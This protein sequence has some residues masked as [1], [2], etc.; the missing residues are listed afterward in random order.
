MKFA[1]C[2]ET[3]EGW[4]FPDVCAHL[5]A[6][7]YQG[8]EIAPFTLKEDPRELTVAEAREHRAVAEDAGLEIVGLHWL[9]VKPSW[10][11]MT[12]P[13]DLLR[14][15]TVKF[16]AHLAKICGAMGGNVMV[17]GSPRQRNLEKD[18]EYEAAA[19]RAA[20]VLRAA[21]EAA[22]DHGV[23]IALEPLGRAET[24]FLTTAAEGV[25]LLKRV[26]HPACRLHLD[27]KA[28]SDEPD[29]IPDIIRAQADYLAHFHAND[30]NLRGPGFGEVKFEP[31]AAALREVKYDGWVSVEVFD[32]RPDPETIAVESL[33]YLRETFGVDRPT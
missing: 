32:Y 7:G 9:L 12:T 24:N 10:L 6:T 14:K 1:F 4:S 16:A 21:A 8:I 17:W 25:E 22:A 11:H 15:D 19:E 28:M 23:V 27:V 30:P 29:E 26:D 20:G 18:W 33:A 5:A 2:N 13:D 31:I 3:Y